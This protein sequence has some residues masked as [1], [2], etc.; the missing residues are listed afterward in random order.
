[1]TSGRRIEPSLVGPG[2]LV[3]LAETGAEQACTVN[4]WRSFEPEITLP[5][6][7]LRRLKV[8]L[9]GMRSF[10]SSEELYFR[11]GS[12]VL[13]AVYFCYAPDGEPRSTHRFTIERL[14]AEG[15]S[16]L[17]VCAAPSPEQ[18]RRF[19][20][21]D[22]D[23]LL[24]KELRGFDFSGYSVG[25]DFLA[26]RFERVDVLVL[27]DSVLGPFHRLRPLLDSSPWD[28]TGFM[29]AYSIEHHIVSS[30]FYFKGFD[31]RLWQACK[32][33]LF[34]N[35]SFNRQ[36]PVVLLQETRLASVLARSVRVGSILTPSA[37]HRN[38]HYLLGNPKG[39]LSAGFPFLKRSIFT[40]FAADFD[41]G[42]YLDCLAEHGHP[43]P[44]LPAQTT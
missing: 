36:G 42:F 32:T 22:P 12:S 11:K 29:T 28:L 14:R 2:P 10:P 23:A 5:Y 41:T 24:W 15:Y 21:L 8:L 30:A 1:M 43:D 26:Q 16:V 3:V 33:V 27:N 31:Y 18:A 40:K 17:V 44:S 19:M 39:L 34:R 20:T 13:W 6:L 25:L 38:L 7:R 37:E 4:T 9:T 35:I